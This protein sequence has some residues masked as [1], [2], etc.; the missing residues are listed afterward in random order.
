MECSWKVLIL[1]LLT[2][3]LI[4][5]CTFLFVTIKWIS[6][7]NRRKDTN[8]YYDKPCVKIY[9]NSQPCQGGRMEADNIIVQD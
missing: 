4:G 9:S 5:F 6:I 7:G 8:A 3:L 1:L 2:F